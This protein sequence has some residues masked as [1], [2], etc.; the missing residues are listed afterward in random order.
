MQG[1]CRLTSFILCI[2]LVFLSLSSPAALKTPD[3]PEGLLWFNASKPVQLSEIKDHFVLLH[4]GIYSVP[5]ADLT[6]DDL[7]ALS[8]KY[9]N[10]IVIVGLHAAKFFEPS[11]F[12]DIRRTIQEEDVRFPVAVDQNLAAWKAFHVYALPMIILIS[13]DGEVLLRKPGGDVFNFVDR[14]L[15]KRMAKYEDRLSHRPWSV[16]PAKSATE[17]PARITENILTDGNKTPA[18]DVTQSVGPQTAGAA[19]INFDFKNYVG[20]DV[21]INREYSR[22]VVKIKLSFVMPPKT[23]LLKTLQSYVRVFTDQG[24]M[25]GGLETPDPN[26][27]IPVDREIEGDRL[28]IEAAFYY[29]REGGLGQFKGL[30]FTVPLADYSKSENIELNYNVSNP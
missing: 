17:V 22:H 24:E 28:F 8:L 14:I 29:S 20:E 30:L 7:K 25:I 4:F 16:P 3:L 21:R 13:P 26:V 2:S 11:S 5:N 23:H 18:I 10:E 12:D 15:S 9:P 27:E 19:F 1:V 6:V